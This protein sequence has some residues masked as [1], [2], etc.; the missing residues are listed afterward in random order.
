VQ[1]LQEENAQLR[2]DLRALN[3]RIGGLEAQLAEARPQD[4]LGAERPAAPPPKRTYYADPVPVRNEPDKNDR[5]AM[6]N[7][8]RAGGV[9]IDGKPYFQ[10][11]KDLSGPEIQP[12]GTVRPQERDATPEPESRGHNV[13]LAGLAH[14][15]YFDVH[16]HDSTIAQRQYGLV[17]EARAGSNWEHNAAGGVNKATHRFYSEDNEIKSK[18]LERWS[19]YN[20]ETGERTAPPM[21]GLDPRARQGHGR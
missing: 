9:Q 6:K 4:P 11:G 16:Y 17:K 14:R 5:Q 3:R 7:F 20:I 21:R 12:Y 18:A 1:R 15:L 10:I 8:Y 2:E 13:N 19:I